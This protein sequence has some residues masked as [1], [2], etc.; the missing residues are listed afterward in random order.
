MAV[1]P[2]FG[3]CSATENAGGGC[4]FITSW[5][6][7]WLV[8]VVFMGVQNGLAAIV[9]MAGEPSPM[10]CVAP[11]CHCGVARCPAATLQALVCDGERRRLLRRCPALLFGC[12]KPTPSP[13]PTLLPAGRRPALLP[14]GRQP[15]PSPNRSLRGDPISIACPR[16]PT[17]RFN[18]PGSKK[19]GNWCFSGA[20]SSVD[21]DS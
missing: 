7:R 5:L 9:F 4:N 13:T 3:S 12:R 10:T 15:T 2:C 18:H 19:A 21:F 20:S 14:S 6:G 1:V 8:A 11:W 16:E 17:T